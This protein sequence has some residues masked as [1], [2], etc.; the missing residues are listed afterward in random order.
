MSGFLSVVFAFEHSIPESNND[1]KFECRSVKPGLHIVVRVAEHTCD[2]ASKRILKPS[3]N[4]LQ[5]FLVR[6]QHL[7]SLLPH[8]DQII[9]GQLGKDVLRPMLTT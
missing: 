6:D 1:S 3:T 4:R 9:A 7:R 5:I 2:D 8:V